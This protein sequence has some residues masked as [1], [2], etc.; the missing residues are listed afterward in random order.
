MEENKDVQANA[1]ATANQRPTFLTVLCILTF[2][3]SGLLL[4][5]SILGLFAAGALE[6]MAKSMP[7]FTSGG[8]ILKSIILVVLAAGS[9]YGA[10]MM[11]QLKKMG[12]YLYALANI[13]LVIISFGWV[14]LIITAAFIIMYFVNL[15]YM[16]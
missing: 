7:G 6:G 13:I 1:Q 10:I 5:F 15:K 4:L 8:G 9:L 16:E 3:G 14:N 11:W 2:I 12:F